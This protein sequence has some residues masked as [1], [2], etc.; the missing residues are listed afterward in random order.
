[1]QQQNASEVVFHPNHYHTQTLP[2]NTEITSD[3]V[4]IPP[5]SVPLSQP[6]NYLEQ[7][8]E[9]LQDLLREQESVIEE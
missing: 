7:E 5:D 6:D 2:Q 8:M 9:K 1:M 3:Q 4:V